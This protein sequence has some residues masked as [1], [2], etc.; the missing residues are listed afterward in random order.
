MDNQD[1][2]HQPHNL[3]KQL[4]QQKLDELSQNVKD[5]VRLHEKGWKVK[6][7]KTKH[8]YFTSFVE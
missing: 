8:C 1:M 3:M 6:K 4:E 5:N 7:A 2:N